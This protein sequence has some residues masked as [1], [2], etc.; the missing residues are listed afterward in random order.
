MIKPFFGQFLLGMYS[1]SHRYLNIPVQLTSISI[2]SVYIQK[3][4]SLHRSPAIGS[5][6]LVPL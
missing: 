4:R 1:F 2:G 5:N 6:Y 3:A